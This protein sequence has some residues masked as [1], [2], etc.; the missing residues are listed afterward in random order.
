MRVL[1]LYRT[2]MPD[3]HG[4]IEEAIHQICLATKKLGVEQRILTLSPVE[5][6]EVISLPEADV[7]RV[8]L[9]IEPAS[10]SMGIQLFNEYRKQ[11]EWADVIHIHYPWPFADLVQVLSGVKKPIIV[12][13]HS[14]IIKQNKLEKVYAPLRWAFFRSVDH[15]VATSP[16]YLK[17]SPLLGK[18]IMGKAKK[19][20]SIAPLGLDP[21]SYSSPS[22]EANK[23]V[24]ENFGDN[25][26]LF[27][28]VLRYYKGLKHLI[29]AAQ[30]TDAK[31]VIAGEGPEGESLRRKAS[32]LGLTN[33]TFTG[34]VSDDLKK[35]LFKNSRGVLFPSCERSEAFGVTLLEGQLYSKPLISCEI[36]TGTS[37]VNLHNETGIVIP[38]FDAQ[39]LADAIETLR[40]NPDMAEE[41][42]H[43]G[44]QRLLSHFSGD[45]VGKTYL[46]LYEQ[47]LE[48]PIENKLATGINYD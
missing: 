25:Y 20:V 39:A 23:Y 15:F 31:I 37:Y 10:C 32:A 38:P 11:A 41:Y 13:Y 48:K 16:N 6:T 12:T 1:Q 24:E 40:T 46:E 4:G 30:K 33:V 47:L 5:K 36:G 3:T 27:L 8:P 21:E 22:D 42:G 45:Q 7:I 18:L 17:T 2:Y 9:Q 19:P 26:F 14:D 43:Q 34:Q 28:G 35:A 44:H 29:D